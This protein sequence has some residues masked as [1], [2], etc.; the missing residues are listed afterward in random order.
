VIDILR[1]TAN[2][3]PHGVLILDERGTLIASNQPANAIFGY[4][5]GALIGQAIETLVPDSSRLLRVDLWKRDSQASADRAVPRQQTVSGLRKDGASVPVEIALN[6]IDASNQRYVVASI[7]NVAD[8]LKLERDLLAVGREGLAFQ[9]LMADVAASFLKSD[10]ATLDTMVADLLRLIAQVLEL[11]RIV[12]WRWSADASFID[13]VH[14]WS[15]PSG[16]IPTDPLP[17]A[18]APYTF[19]RL[20]AG[21]AVSFTALEELPDSVDRTTFRLRGERSALL[22]PMP[23][24]GGGTDVHWVLTASSMTRELEWPPAIVERLR[25]VAGVISQALAR[26]ASQVAL[27]QALDDLHQLRTRPSE[28]VVRRPD[29]PRT[30]AA[31]RIVSESADVRDALLQIEQVAG[32]S[33]TVLLRGETGAGKE[34]FAQAIHDLSPRHRRPMVIVSCAAIPTALIESELFGRE[35]GAYTGALSRQIGRFEAA[36]QST[37]FLDEIGDLPAEMQVKLLRVLQERVIERLGSTQP[38]KVDVR[39]I[40][41]THRDLEQAVRDGTFRE[42]LFYRLNVFPI[43]VPP[44][45]ERIAD[46]PGLVWAFV[47]ELSRAFG[48]TI[49]SIAPASMQELQRYPWPGNVRELRNVIERAVILATT[50]H[51]VVPMPHP[52]TTTPLPPTAMTLASLETEHIRTILD[53]THW[54]VRG[55]GGAAERLGLKPTTLESRMARLG[56]VRER[57]S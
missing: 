14:G 52:T 3:C 43:R 23:Y 29:G 10:P 38:I 46:I 48:K 41:A 19:A 25:L 6:I 55:R 34:V 18:S 7:D 16:Q 42:D 35:R 28:A 20:E 15:L 31:S 8:R 33:A 53:S 44:L 26:R 17:V 45:R 5:P 56:I 24:Q 51:L 2:D 47:D 37:L 39:I 9:R 1:A 30:G 36:H 32:T 13:P 4:T 57:A 27:Q 54:R 22:I 50:E 12:L 21:E 49:T 40:A 11:D